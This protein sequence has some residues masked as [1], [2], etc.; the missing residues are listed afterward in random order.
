MR[1]HNYTKAINM[2]CKRSRVGKPA[3]II[4]GCGLEGPRSTHFGSRDKGESSCWPSKKG[5]F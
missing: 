4:P 2:P 1:H 3:D 5:I